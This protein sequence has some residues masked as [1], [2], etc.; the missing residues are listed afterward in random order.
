MLACSRCAAPSRVV[1][2]VIAWAIG[3]ALHTH[4]ADTL[5][6]AFEFYDGAFHDRSGS[7][8]AAG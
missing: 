7:H 6:V 4:A 1:A 8:W 3:L 2:F 5:G